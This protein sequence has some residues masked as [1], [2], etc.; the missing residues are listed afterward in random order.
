LATR[1]LGFGEVAF[2][3]KAP[4]FPVFHQSTQDLARSVATWAIIVKLIT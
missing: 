1:Y 4:T 3:E 2:K